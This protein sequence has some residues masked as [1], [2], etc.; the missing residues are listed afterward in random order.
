MSGNP[1]VIAA[2]VLVAMAG[3]MALTVMVRHKR[4]RAATLGVILRRCRWPTVL[5]AAGLA[6][7][8]HAGMIALAQ[9]SVAQILPSVIMGAGIFYC[10]AEYTLG[11]RR[12]LRS[13]LALIPGGI[14]TVLIG[15]APLAVIAGAGAAAHMLFIRRGDPAEALAAQSVIAALISTPAFFGSDPLRGQAQL[16]ALTAA[17]CFSFGIWGLH[18][19]AYRGVLLLA[20]LTGL[21][22]IWGAY[23]EPQALMA[24]ILSVAGVAGLQRMIGSSGS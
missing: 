8:M 10:V 18:R 6:V 1:T 4:G 2:S 13:L 23:S 14:G 3:M 19:A 21:A 5:G 9:H 12:G 11:N 7:A 15:I 16:L 24:V 22:G 17:G 20:G